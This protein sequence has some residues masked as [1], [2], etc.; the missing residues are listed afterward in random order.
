MLISL[1]D[2]FGLAFLSFGTN[3]GFILPSWNESK[4][5]VLVVENFHSQVSPNGS[6]HTFS[7]TYTGD[8][9]VK[10]FMIFA[11]CVFSNFWQVMRHISFII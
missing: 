7:A 1:E 4:L 2:A 6:A 8:S 9:I 10:L 3:Y 11:A 5:L